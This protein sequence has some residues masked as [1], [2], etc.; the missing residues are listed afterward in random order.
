MT[1]QFSLEVFGLP[2]ICMV[3]NFSD[4]LES[5]ECQLLRSASQKLGRHTNRSL[6]GRRKV[7]RFEAK[8]KEKD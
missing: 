7:V 4:Q 1:L 6:N 8:L 5:M 2:V 3:E